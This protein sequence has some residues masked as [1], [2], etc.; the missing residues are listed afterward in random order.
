MA[1]NAKCELTVCY[2]ALSRDREHSNKCATYKIALANNNDFQVKN[3][4][5]EFVI[6]ISVHSPVDQCP[7]CNE[8][9]GK[10]Q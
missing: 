3:F 9:I 7:H 8:N 2:T 4:F 5:D 10:K 1:K 6:Y